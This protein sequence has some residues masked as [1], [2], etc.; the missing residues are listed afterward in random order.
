MGVTSRWEGLQVGVTS[1]WEGLAGGGACYLHIGQVELVGLGLSLEKPEEGAL[2]WDMGVVMSVSRKSRARS[3][4]MW[5]RW[6]ARVHKG[7]KV[8]GCRTRICPV[9]NPTNSSDLE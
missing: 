7:A 5:L 1:R 9:L 4:E 2:P 3:E 8:R 6:Q